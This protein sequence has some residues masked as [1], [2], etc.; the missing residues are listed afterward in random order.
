MRAHP[1]NHL[2]LFSGDYLTKRIAM[3][4]PDLNGTHT[5]PC[6][7]NLNPAEPKYDISVK[8]EISTELIIKLRNNAYNRAEANDA[9]NH[10]TRFLQII[11]LVK[12]PNVNTEQLCILT[13]PYSLTGEAHRWWVHEGN[14]KITSWVE[15]VD[16]FFYKYYPLS[17]ACRM[18]CTN[19]ERES[20]KRF[21]NW[22]NSRFKNLWK[23]KTVTKN[24]LWN[25]WEKGYDND[26]LIDDEESSDD[27]SNESNQHPFFNPYQN[28]KEKGDRSQHTE[29]NDNTGK[30]ENFDT[31]HSDVK[32]RHDEGMYRVDRFEV[33]KY[34]IR[35][36]EEFMGIRKLKRHSWAQTVNEI[37]SIYLD[38]FRKKDE[39]WTV[40]RTK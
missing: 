38:I 3:A 30:L 35:D 2:C 20:H 27:E 23:L 21:M 22:L 11:D 40:H 25:F 1:T 26:T 13:F 10:I 16:K 7:S 18:D 36:N 28:D 37:S 29:C 14:S 17:H 19:R 31:T 5:H 24:A 8:I 39:G 6:L 32:E 33:I 12:T 9:L 15:I 34:L 4:P